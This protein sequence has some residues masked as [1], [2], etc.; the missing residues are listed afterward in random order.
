[1]RRSD[2]DESYVLDLCDE[3]LNCKG[4]RQATFDF[5]RGDPYSSNP[6]GRKLPVDAYYRELH[7]VVEYHERQHS[8]PV[9]H[10]DKP[11]TLTIS[12][13]DRGTQRA[14]YDARRRTVLPRHGIVVVTIGYQDFQ[15]K[16]NRLVRTP[17]DI[18][19]V[20]RILKNWTG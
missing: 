8:E 17:S 10:F 13:V 4:K 9:A 14:L 18:E 19:T 20:R 5:L 12:G 11:G 6:E 15:T 1:M 7:L 3:V 16:G 2:S